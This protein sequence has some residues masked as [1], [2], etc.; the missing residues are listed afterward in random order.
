MRR[1][2]LDELGAIRVTE[3]RRPD[4]QG[5]V[6]RLI[7]KGLSPSTIQVTL[8]PLRALFRR[9]LSRGELAVNPCSG[10]ELPAIRGR[11]ERY[12]SPEEAQALIDAV[13]EAD[14]AIWATAMYGGLRLGELRGLRV[15]DVD[16][17]AGVIR[18]ERGWDVSEGE[19]ELKS[20]AGRRKVPIPAV[21]RDHL[22]E[23]K[24]A[25]GREGDQLIFGRTVHDPFG[26][27]GLQE[28]AD[29]A[30]KAGG[31]DRITPHA[32]R[33]TFASL[34]IA[35]GVNAKALSTFMGHSN[36]S[37]TLDRYGHLMPGS[38]EEAALLLDSYLAAERDRAE[39][40]ARAAEPRGTMVGQ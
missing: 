17:A 16:L 24:I 25:T 4:V 23:R 26:P 36:I 29:A 21:L 9:A 6:D 13:P 32:C 10:L 19:I 37:I 7:A 18:V 39:D 30:W 38:E 33:H 22:V 14:R 12:A 1:R 3:V 15:Q 31:L 8:L 5:F 11:R 20:N 40:Q 35:A 28:R 2:V 34:M 27:N